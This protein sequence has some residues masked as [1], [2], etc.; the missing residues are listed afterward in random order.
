MGFFER[1]LSKKFHSSAKIIGTSPPNNTKCFQC[2]TAKIEHTM[3]ARNG[4]GTEW[5]CSVKQAILITSSI[6][7]QGNRIGPVCV[8][9]C[10]GL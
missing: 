3:I 10:L 2:L 7:G 9:V 6:S 5:Q 4:S 1:F 8:C